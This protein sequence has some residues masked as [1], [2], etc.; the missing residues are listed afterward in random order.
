MK[1]EIICAHLLSYTLSI[2]IPL[3]TKKFIQAVDKGDQQARRQLYERY[4][5]P[6]FMVCLRYAR[7]RSEAEDILQEGFL[8]IFKDIKQ[9]RGDG[10]LEGWL[11]RVMVNAALRYLRKWKRSFVE[12]QAEVEST[13]TIYQPSTV[14]DDQ[15]LSAQQLTKII[16]ELPIGYRTV[17]NMYVMDGYTHQEI[18][19]YL[20]ISPGTS[21]SQLSK[22]R[23]LLKQKVEHYLL[24]L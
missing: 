6:L 4:R 5:T 15:P 12:L 23:K 2:E 14:Q 8:V 17:F 11:K 24:E 20:N 16:Q 22:A 13:E 7:D 1:L 18:A 19:T 9:Y 10:N 3:N 21:K